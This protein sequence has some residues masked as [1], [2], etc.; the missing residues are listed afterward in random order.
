MKTTATLLDEAVINVFSGRLRRDFHHGIA[1]FAE[2][3][4]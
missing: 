1:R 4:A 3:S 2:G